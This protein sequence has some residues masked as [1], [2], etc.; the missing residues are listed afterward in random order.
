MI[1]RIT[2][3]A[4]EYQW[5]WRIIRYQNSGAHW[6]IQPFMRCNAKTVDMTLFHIY[7]KNACSL[8]RIYNKPQSKYTAYLTKSFY[9]QNYSENI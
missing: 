3:R 7:W 4:A 9:R 8:C 1:D 5:F 2:A 6:R